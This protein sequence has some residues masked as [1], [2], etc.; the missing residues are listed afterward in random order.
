MKAFKY[1]LC[2]VFI[3]GGLSSAVASGD[4]RL[5]QQGTTPCTAVASPGDADATVGSDGS[6][7]I[8]RPAPGSEI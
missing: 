8:R 5:G 7:T 1:I 4:S 6:T 2:L 3:L